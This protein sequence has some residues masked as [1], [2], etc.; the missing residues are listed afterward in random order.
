LL[1]TRQNRHNHL[2][3]YVINNGYHEAEIRLRIA[4]AT[5]ELN[6]HYVVM[7]AERMSL[8]NADILSR[9]IIAGKK[10]RNISSNTI[11]TYIDGVAY[12]ENYHHHKDLEKIDKN[13][14]TSFLDSYRKSEARDPLHRWINTYNIRYQILF[15]F[16]KWLYNLKYDDESKKVSIP[17]VMNGIKRLKRK[18]KSSYQVK[19][20]WTQEDDAIFLKYCE[21]GR[22]RCYHMI[23]RDT[24][25]RPHELLKLH[26][27]DIMW[28]TSGTA[29]YAEVTIGKSG[30]TEPRTTPLIYSI[31]FVK[32]WLREHPTGTNRNS[33]LF[34]SFEKQSMYRNLPLKPLSLSNMYRHLKLEFFPRLLTN[35]DVPEEDKNKIRVLLEK[36]WNPYVRRHTS[37]NEIWKLVKSEH[38]LRLH[39]GW[40]KNSKMVEIYTHEFS[41]E[42]SQLL[43]QARG[44][45]PA[46]AQEDNILKPRQC[47]HCNEPNKP[48]IRFCTKCG[49]VLA[50]DAYSETLEIQKQKEESFKNMEKQVNSMQSQLQSLISVLG[51]MDGD[52]KNSF[53]KDLFRSGIL[54]VNNENVIVAK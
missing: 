50:Y 33:H 37:L 35:P 8:K 3:S 17:P 14:I 30:K 10:E 53:A 43:L 52:R 48:D 5:S 24:S 1:K 44:I 27:G 51:S 12:L 42:S 47:P 19:D 31:P 32:D 13:D 36:P 4:E 6:K 11:M 9:F 49:M 39:A 22:L 2:N 21:D 29:Q 38:A 25:G 7:V 46:N 23:A 26:V 28:Q 20:L 40:S 34:I 18:E 16:F 54:E 45:I 41:N 15:K